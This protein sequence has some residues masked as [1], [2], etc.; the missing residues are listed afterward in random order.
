MELGLLAPWKVHK[1]KASSVCRSRSSHRKYSLGRPDQ[2][3][4]SENLAAT[5]GLADMI[6]EAQ[7]LFQVSK[8]GPRRSRPPEMYI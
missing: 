2:R 1:S 8:D 7:R 3:D 4:L 5:Q 6:T